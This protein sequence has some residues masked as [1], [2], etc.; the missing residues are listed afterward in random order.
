MTNASAPWWEVI[1]LRDE[2]ISS[3]AVPLTMF[4]CRCTTPYLARRE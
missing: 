4:R 3:G 2:V 1:G